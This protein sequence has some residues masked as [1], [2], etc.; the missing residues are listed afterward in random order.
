MA[1]IV[2]PRVVAILKKMLVLNPEER[3]SAADILSSDTLSNESSS[4]PLDTN[5]EYP[6]LDLT[7]QEYDQRRDAFSRLFVFHQKFTFPI[8]VY[9]MACWLLDMVFLGMG[10]KIE[11]ASIACYH[12]SQTSSITDFSKTLNT[13]YDKFDHYNNRRPIHLHN[14]RTAYFEILKRLRI[15]TMVT[16]PVDYVHFYSKR[17]TE[18]IKNYAIQMLLQLNK[19]DFSFKCHAKQIALASIYIA[20]VYHKE[21]FIHFEELDVNIGPIDGKIV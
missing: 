11:E 17:Y 14:V 16:L 1:T 2:E 4:L 15:D 6:R 18:E 3:S 10:G 21:P 9:F 7:Q 20:C 12:I 19:M 13:V 8:R 5:A